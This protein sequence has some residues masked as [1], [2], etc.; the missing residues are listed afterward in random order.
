M[1]CSKA[2]SINQAS[3]L[4]RPP[5]LHRRNRPTWSALWQLQASRLGR[6]RQCLRAVV[7]SHRL[8]SAT[9]AP[10]GPRPKDVPLKSLDEANLVDATPPES[11]VAGAPGSAWLIGTAL[12]PR[13]SDMVAGP[14]EWPAP[15]TRAHLA[16]EHPAVQDRQ[17]RRA[18]QRSRK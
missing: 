10:P 1:T 9:K 6:T 4:F 5:V 8:E 12:P 14:L 7:D 15:Q 13:K 3:G 18:A 2:A 11:L 17:D 16:H